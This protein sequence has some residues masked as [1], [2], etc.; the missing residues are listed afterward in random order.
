MQDLSRSLLF[1]ELIKHPRCWVGNL[2][3]G[4]FEIVNKGR[5][6]IHVCIYVRVTE[7]LTQEIDLAFSGSHFIF[8]FGNNVFDVSIFLIEKRIEKFRFRYEYFKP[9]KTIWYTGL[10][11]VRVCKFTF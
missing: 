3:D 1:L 5:V 4:V 2:S 10:F 11:S 9:I 7:R 6:S 8:K